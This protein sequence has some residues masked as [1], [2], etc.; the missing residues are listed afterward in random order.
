[1]TDER[2]T[3]SPKLI[4]IQQGKNGPDIE[5]YSRHGRTRD[6]RTKNLPVGSTNRPNIEKIR[7]E[8]TMRRLQTSKPTNRVGRT[9]HTGP[10]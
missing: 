8:K 5:Y 9:P 4:P 1:M 10:T 7:V 2:K 3:S 6:D